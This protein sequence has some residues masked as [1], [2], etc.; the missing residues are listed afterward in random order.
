MIID[1][2]KVANQLRQAYL[3]LQG[4]LRPTENRA[5]TKYMKHNDFDMAW[6]TLAVGGV[7]F[8]DDNFWIKMGQ[9]AEIMS[10]DVKRLYATGRL[11]R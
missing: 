2:L 10:R 4:K 5:F 11:K 8:G 1:G 3:L 7:E 6:D 9:I